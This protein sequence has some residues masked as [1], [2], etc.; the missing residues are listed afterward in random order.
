MPGSFPLLAR[1]HVLPVSFIASELG[2]STARDA[3]EFLKKNNAAFF[4]GMPTPNTQSTGPW[5]PVARDTPDADKKLDCK[6]AAANL[7]SAARKH[8]KLDIPRI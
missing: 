4:Q 1:Y 7:E 2:F 5:K 8:Q 3:V 6:L